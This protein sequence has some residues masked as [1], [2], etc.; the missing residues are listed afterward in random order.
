M[1]LKRT[2]FPFFMLLTTVSLFGQARLGSSALEIRQE[3]N[4]I[5][6]DLKSGYNEDGSYFISIRTDRALVYYYFD[7]NKVCNAT[8]IA[9]HNQGFLN[10]YVE[11]YNSKYVI[12]SETKWKMYSGGGVATVELIFPDDGGYFFFWTN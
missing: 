7:E 2:L 12:L 9:P 3:F 10:F 4:S 5:A 11:D 6:S 8:G 1:I